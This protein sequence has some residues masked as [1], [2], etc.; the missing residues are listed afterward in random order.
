MKIVR[1]PNKVNPSR[2]VSGLAA[3]T[4]SY[5]SN[6]RSPN[7]ADASYSS[8]TENTLDGVFSEVNTNTLD[9]C[10]IA[11]HPRWCNWVN[12]GKTMKLRDEPV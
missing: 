4:V 6:K 12:A 2:H 10:L 7:V 3:R 5:R 1:S 8:T 9:S 11:V